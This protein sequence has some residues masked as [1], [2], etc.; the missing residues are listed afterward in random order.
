MPRLFALADLHLSLTGD[1]PMDVFGE[2]WRDHASRMAAAWDARV[3]PDDTVL[4]PGDL[5]WGGSLD[6]AAEDLAWIGARPG[7]K[8]LLRGNHDSWW[9]SASKVRA[10]LPAG[11]AILQHDAHLVGDRVVLGA[12]GWLAPDDPAATAH[13]AAVFRREVA[14]L[15]LSVQD[16]DRRFG[17]DLPRVAMLHYP[18]WI[19]GR[20]ATEVVGI[21]REAGVSVCV[22]GHLHGADVGLGVQGVRD[23]IRFRLV[24][25]D[26]VGFAPVVIHDPTDPGTSR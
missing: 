10:A 25:A 22:Y 21:L 20:A 19:E 7:R 13:D 11:C 8:I 24:S 26:A 2:A 4:L 23:G 15:V 3:G 14:R 18:P 9:G 5:S 6:E 12:R 17:R 1:K 16:A